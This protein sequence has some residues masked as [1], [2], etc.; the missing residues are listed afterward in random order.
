MYI[1]DLERVDKAR[2]VPPTHPFL[3]NMGAR[4]G[5]KRSCEGKDTHEYRLGTLVIFDWYVQ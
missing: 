1:I 3:L 4:K 5:L 2:L